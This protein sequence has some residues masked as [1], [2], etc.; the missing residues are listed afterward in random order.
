MSWEVSAGAVV[1][2]TAMVAGVDLVLEAAPREPRAPRVARARQG[3]V[4]ADP[5]AARDLAADWGVPVA[6]PR[7]RLRLA[8][9]GTGSEATGGGA[10]TGS[11]GTLPEAGTSRVGVA[12]TGAGEEAD[13]GTG[14]GLAVFTL[15]EEGASALTEETGAEVFAAFLVSGVASAG[16]SGTGPGKRSCR[17]WLRVTRVGAP[18]GA[19]RLVGMVRDGAEELQWRAERTFG[20]ESYRIH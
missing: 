20:S 12:G 1:V 19:L 18:G 4:G 2:A 13:S 15:S 7:P 5:R 11:A 6:R 10:T 3:L 14:A 16:G 17:V 9:A 8:G